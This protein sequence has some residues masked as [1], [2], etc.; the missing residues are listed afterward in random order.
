MIVRIWH[1][2]TKPE[3]ADAYTDLLR[4]KVLPGIH[5]VIGYKG[6]YLLR[7]RRA[8]EVEFVTLTLW[9]SMD[10]VAE[11]AGD[12]S[13][14]AVVPEEARRLLERFDERSEHYEAEWVA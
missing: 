11:F 9:D 3:N 5:R 2:Y 7:R 6:T 4:T 1:G 10:A 12:E 14:H 13:S 8:L